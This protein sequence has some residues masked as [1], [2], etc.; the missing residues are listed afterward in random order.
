MYAFYKPELAFI[1]II[2]SI[3]DP[4]CMF[5]SYVTVILKKGYN[6]QNNSYSVEDFYTFLL[7]V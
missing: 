6:H 7:D 1:S 5:S 4:N 2:S 3:N